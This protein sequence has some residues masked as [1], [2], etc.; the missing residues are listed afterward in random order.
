MWQMAS[1]PGE[2]QLCALPNSYANP[3]R[4]SALSMGDPC[5][6]SGIPGALCGVEFVEL[7]L[8]RDAVPPLVAGMVPYALSAKYSRGAFHSTAV[9]TYSNCGGK[10]GR[11]SCRERV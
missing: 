1:R 10:I 2:C 4:V 7:P 8:F 11:A 9:L 5:V 6:L 3:L